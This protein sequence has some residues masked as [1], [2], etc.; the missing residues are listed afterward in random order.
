VAGR[1]ASLFFIMVNREFFVI[2]YP[3]IY[4]LIKI[5]KIAS[6]ISKGHR[7]QFLQIIVAKY[8]KGLGWP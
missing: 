6:S 3:K 7:K 4:D 1:E 5:Y 2:Y 8:R